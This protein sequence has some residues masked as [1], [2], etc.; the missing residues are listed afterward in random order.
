MVGI[1]VRAH[2]GVMYK[3]NTQPIFIFFKKEG[4]FQYLNSKILGST[5]ISLINM[6]VSQVI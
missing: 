6:D 2:R 5:K 1:G 4:V 3:K